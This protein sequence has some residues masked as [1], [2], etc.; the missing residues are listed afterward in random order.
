LHAEFGQIE[1][2]NAITGYADETTIPMAYVPCL[3]SNYVIPRVVTMPEL[4]KNQNGK[5]DRKA[6]VGL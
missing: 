3:L 2:F 4:P 5:V 1:A 6:L